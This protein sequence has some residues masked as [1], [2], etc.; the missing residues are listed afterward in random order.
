M[1]YKI[2]H[3]TYMFLGSHFKLGKIVI[4]GGQK[5]L[6]KNAVRFSLFQ[7]QYC[8]IQFHRVLLRVAYPGQL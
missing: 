8:C 7:S 5:L 2:Q 4:R 3:T 1:V 6:V